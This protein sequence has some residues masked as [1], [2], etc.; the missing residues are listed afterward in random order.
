MQI[1]VPK[2]QTIII[3]IIV[4]NDYYH[5]H[6]HY[7]DQIPLSLI[8][9]NFNITI[10]LHALKHA[11]PREHTSCDTGI[12]YTHENRFNSPDAYIFSWF[13]IGGWN[14]K[15]HAQTRFMQAMRAVSLLQLCILLVY[16]TQNNN[17]KKNNAPLCFRYFTSQKEEYTAKPGMPWC[18][19]VCSNMYV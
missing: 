16:Q 1:N 9:H 17:N 6:H 7:I 12:V 3:I 11:R 13:L 10:L 14:M 15:L 2:K 5:H 4:I 19:S 18:F 8:Y